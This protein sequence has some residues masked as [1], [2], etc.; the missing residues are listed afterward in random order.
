MKF[1]I[2]NIRLINLLFLLLLIFVTYIKYNNNLENKVNR[3]RKFKKNHNL[4]TKNFE[5]ELPE[6]KKYIKEL[7]ENTTCNINYYNDISNPKISFISSVYNKEQYLSSFISSIQNQLLNEFEIILVDDCST[8][9]S[10]KIINKY[11][12]NDKRIKLIK[13]KT[14]MGS[15]NARYKGAIH[16]RGEY[17]IFVDSDDI[18]LKNGIIKAYNHIKN[19][20]LDMVEFHSVFDNINETYICRRYYKYLDI[21]Y[22]PIL[23]YLFYI[24]NNN[25]DEQNT[26]LWDKLIKREVVMK[27][28]N[29]IGKKYLNEKII[30][31]N[32]VLLLFSFFRNSNS[33][34]YIDEL[35]YYYFEKNKDS[36]TNTRYD[37]KKANQIIHSIFTNINFLYE[38]TGDTFLD[39]YYCVFK[40]KQAYR[41]Y[42][43][44]FNNTNQEYDIVENVFNK[45]L[46]SKYIS[47][48]NKLE[49]KEIK[50]N[51]LKIYNQKKV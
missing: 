40:V 21:I 20:N 34:Q 13:N 47:I 9:N 45:L 50:L 15:I 8:D 35:G 27:S 22:Q 32:D 26:A 10:I 38:N 48:E 16:S 37:P 4:P 24:K 44:C 43:I 2:K 23:S 28:L 41:R 29:Y 1:N 19:N 17:I 30:I 25:G 7:R 42:E 46:E 49:I 5:I 12:K 31:E 36:I 39:K 18:V 11:Q 6:I 33:Y 51:I 14:N 3:Y